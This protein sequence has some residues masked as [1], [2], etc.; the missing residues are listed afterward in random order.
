[1]L[2]GEDEGKYVYLGILQF[3][4]YYEKTSLCIDIGGGSTEFIVGKGGKV[5]FAVSLRLGH[6]SLTEGF[7]KIGE[8][9]EMRKHIQYV[10]NQSGLVQKVRMSG[11][12]VVVG[13]SGTIQA[14]ERAVFHGYA[15][16]FVA[17]AEDDVLFGDVRRD[18]RFSRRELSCVVE[19]LCGEEEKIRRDGFFKRRSEFIIAG[20]ILL[21]EI[22]EM[23]GIDEMEVSGYALGEGVIAERL[24]SICEDYDLYVNARWRSIVRLATRLNNKKRMKSAGQCSG[25]GKDIFD[26]LRRCNELADNQNKLISSLDEKDLE[27]LEAACL[28]HN[29]GLFTG[30]KAY[31]KQSYHII[32]NG[33]HLHGY[34]TKEVKLIALLARHHRKK[35]PKFDRASLLEFPKEVKQKFRILCVIVRISVVVQQYQCVN[36]EGISLSDSHEGF[37]MVLSEIKNQ[38]PDAVQSSSEDFESELR[39][40]LEHFEMVYQQNMSVVVSSSISESGK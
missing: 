29:I 13:S 3:L 24:A 8:I 36:F 34:D 26:G 10:I 35:F 22:F 14:I 19:S 9:S 21:E 23:L 32:M 18:W 38:P 16:G 40:E 39:R 31:H 33:D 7:V 27:Y 4:P 28:L 6:V 2:S 5:I 1:M 37:K 25:I 20:A 12:V 17:A 15:Q 30:K 11:F